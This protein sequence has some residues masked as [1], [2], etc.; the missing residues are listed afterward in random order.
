MTLENEQKLL[1]SLYDRLFDAITYVPG[2]NKTANFDRSTT[3]VQFSKNEALN[4]S[5]FKNAQ[6]PM[7]PNGDQRTAAAFSQ[8]VDQVPNIAADFSQSGKTASGSYK[9]IVDN[10]NTDNKIDPA[11]KA[12]YDK[13]YKFLNQ[14]KEL[15]NFDSSKTE[16]IVPTSIAQ[17]YD[18]NQS[19][20]VTAVSGYRIA[21]SGYNLDDVADQRKWQAEAPKLQLLVDQT[22]NKWVREGKQ[23]VEQAQNALRTTINDAVAAAITQAQ[24]AMRDDHWVAP[25]DLGGQ[26]WILSYALPGGWADSATGATE[27]SLKSS[28]LHTSSDSSFTSYGGGASWGAGLW[29]VGGS[30][31]SS[32]GSVQSHMDANTVEISAKLKTVRIMRPWLNAILFTMKGWWL[33]GATV[34]GISNGQLKGNENSVLPLLPTAIVVASDVTIKADFSAQDQSHIEK[35]VSGS[36]RVGWGPFSVGGSY[37]HSESH[38]KLTATYDAGAL[39]IPGMQILA[40]VST[41]TPASPPLGERAPQPARARA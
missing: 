32:E 23:Q 24:D 36:A 1:Q 19:A 20:Y 7:N 9:L 26:K 25:L 28:Y 2:G 16:T 4:P 17:A 11:Q 41:I 34:N 27:F 33:K 10:A 39:R 38:D 12:T 21:Q 31:A 37:S 6:S 40:W 18:D 15:E 5:D 3:F 30:F 13:A 14:K 29:S 35:S 8:M 22:W